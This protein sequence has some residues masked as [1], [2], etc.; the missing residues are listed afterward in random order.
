MALFLM[1]FYEGFRGPTPYGLIF[2]RLSQL[3]QS[4]LGHYAAARSA[5]RFLMHDK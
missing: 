2:S 1:A 5:D 4:A 3:L